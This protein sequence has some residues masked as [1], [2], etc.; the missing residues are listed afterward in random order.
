[1]ADIFAVYGR[2][3]F[4]FILVFNCLLSLFYAV[5]FLI[6]LYTAHWIIYQPY[7]IS[8]D[9]LWAVMIAAIMNLYPSM[10]VGRVHTKRLWFHHYVWGFIVL[11]FSILFIL[12]FTSVSIVNF[13]MAHI[14]DLRVNFGRF[15]FLV[16]L[17]LILDDF[18]DIAKITNAIQTF[19][20]VKIGQNSKIT[21]WIHFLSAGV[22]LY[23]FAAIFV[24]L[25]QNPHGVTAGNLIFAG[26]LFFTI[27]TAFGT[28][29]EKTWLKLSP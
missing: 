16:G 24:W 27:V 15:L 20:K 26:S 25:T 5:G 10:K 9:L 22:C 23:I 7:L 18:G 8:A 1:M 13:F 12:A 29:T 17:T 14:N 2:K 19:L 6:G 4:S 3:L 11:A 28:V 21:Y